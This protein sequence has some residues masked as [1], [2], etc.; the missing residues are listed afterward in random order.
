MSGGREAS[1]G[2]TGTGARNRPNSRRRCLWQFP[3]QRKRLAWRPGAVRVLP[4]RGRWHRSPATA[5]DCRRS[6]HDTPTGH[7]RRIPAYA[8]LLLLAAT[9]A[10]AHAQRAPA[11]NAIG[12]VAGVTRVDGRTGVSFPLM[13]SRGSGRLSG[14]LIGEWSLVPRDDRYELRTEAGVTRCVDTRDGTRADTDRCETDPDDQFAGAIE[15]TYA[16]AR[17]TTT[18]FIG[19]GYRFGWGTTP[20]ATLGWNI[21]MRRSRAVIR[22]S[23]GDDFVQG[24]VGFYWLL[25]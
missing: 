11:G 9:A 22:A 10:T 23:V 12:L 3:L 4:D 15:A 1:L 19:V 24:L 13:I 14:T 16:L 21:G 2:V 20:Y 6:T 7:M 25:R 8:S 18:P 17:T 5:P